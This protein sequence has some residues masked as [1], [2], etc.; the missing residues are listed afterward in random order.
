MNKRDR[1]PSA[2]DPLL[3]SPPPFPQVVAARAGAASVAELVSLLLQTSACTHD[4]EIYTKSIKKVKSRSNG[5]SSKSRTFLSH[6]VYR[7]YYGL[8]RTYCARTVREPPTLH[9]IPS[10]FL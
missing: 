1:S 3:L 9:P 4:R 10:H 2:S 8:L 5:M 7:T 6:P